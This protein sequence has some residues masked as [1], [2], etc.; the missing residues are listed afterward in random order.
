ME[1][2]IHKLFQL[3]RPV[4][5]FISQTVIEIDWVGKIYTFM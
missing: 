2:I 4:Y 5:I 3:S 1:Q